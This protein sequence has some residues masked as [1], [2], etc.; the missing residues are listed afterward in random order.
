L[1][2]REVAKTRKRFL[3]V[4]AT[5]SLSDVPQ[6][7]IV[8]RFLFAEAPTSEINRQAAHY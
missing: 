5:K 3:S 6:F 4:M 1:P 7:A 8:Y 2:M